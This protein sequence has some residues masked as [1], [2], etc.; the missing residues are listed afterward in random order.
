MDRV[1]GYVLRVI[2]GDTFELDV[3]GVSRRNQYLYNDVER[4][5]L[6]GIDA[7]ELN[8]NG[9]PAA[10]A[11]LASEIQGRR[12]TVTVRAR[13]CYRRLVGD[14]SHARRGR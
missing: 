1:T 7:P 5:R 10:K 3:D 14:V 6:Y 11:R 13:D 2:D 4:V 9:G 12:V 8:T